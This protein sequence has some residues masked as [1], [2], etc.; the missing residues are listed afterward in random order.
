MRQN[1]NQNKRSLLSKTL[2]LS[3]LN[4]N[5]NLQQFSSTSLKNQIFLPSM[6][7]TLNYSCTT[8]KTPNN[9]NP[10]SVSKVRVIVRVRPF[11]SHE[12]TR[13]GDDP[14]SCISLLD[15][16]FQFQNDVAVYLKDPF[17]RFQKNSIFKKKFTFLLLLLL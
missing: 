17:T 4:F 11:L 12:I 15:Q 8:P 7:T 5:I 1:P 13:N 10:I 6:A 9:N 2:P 14:V 16:D 3:L